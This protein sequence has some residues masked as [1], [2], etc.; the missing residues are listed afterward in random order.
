MNKFLTIQPADFLPPINDTIDLPK[1]KSAGVFL[2]IWVRS[3]GEMVRNLAMIPWP[4]PST[5]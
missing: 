4:L 5:P 2:S 1:R 3:E